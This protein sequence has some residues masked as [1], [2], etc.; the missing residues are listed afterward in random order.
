MKNH[1]VIIFPLENVNFRG[2]LTTELFS[3]PKYGVRLSSHPLPGAHKLVLHPCGVVARIR[4]AE[5]SV[6]S[7]R[8]QGPGIPHLAIRGH[9]SSLVCLCRALT[10]D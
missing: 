5:R 4:F 3:L 2:K 7:I 9:A 10:E 8:I 6:F 1:V